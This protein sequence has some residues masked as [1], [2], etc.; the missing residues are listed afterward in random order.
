[1][2]SHISKE[3]RLHVEKGMSVYQI[4]TML[5]Q[6]PN[7]VLQ[8]LRNHKVLKKSLGLKEQEKVAKWF[9]DKGYYVVRQKEMLHLIY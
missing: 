1:M 8:N 5:K 4:A 3:I 2:L 9:E 6:K 7:T